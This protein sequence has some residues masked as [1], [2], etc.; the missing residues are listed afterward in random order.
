MCPE[1]VKIEQ[2]DVRPVL[3]HG[4]G[5]TERASETTR[6]T[7]LRR[8]AASSDAPED[9]EPIDVIP[10]ASV[11]SARGRV[12]S[13]LTTI[14][15]II[16]TPFCV[17]KTHQNRRDLH[18]E[19]HEIRSGEHQIGAFRFFS[20]KTRFLKAGGIA[21]F[22]RNKNKTFPPPP[23]KKTKPTDPSWARWFRTHRTK[24][25]KFTR[26]KRTEKTLVKSNRRLQKRR[27]RHKTQLTQIV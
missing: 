27:D 24:R 18:R 23:K 22:S 6:T 12:T 26:K 20:D 16:I 21:F 19:T 11:R 5:N 10:V 9:F 13:T 1:A 7:R 25:R 8:S 14:C 17:P 4:H 3:Y 15:I 2:Y